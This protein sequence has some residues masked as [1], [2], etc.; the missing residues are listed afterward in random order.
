MIPPISLCWDEI[1]RE[2]YKNNFIFVSGGWGWTFAWIIFACFTDCSGFCF[3]SLS[4]RTINHVILSLNT[5]TVTLYRRKVLFFCLINLPLWFLGFLWHYKPR[6]PFFHYLFRWK[7]ADSDEKKLK[8]LAE[9]LSG[10]LLPF[11]LAGISKFIFG[12]S[13]LSTMLCTSAV[14]FMV[15]GYFSEGC[16]SW[17]LRM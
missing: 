14:F 16:R 1:L 8:S 6:L 7:C 11:G 3:P 17:I 5:C 13:R 15:V 9:L 10:L 2:G 12:L 4:N